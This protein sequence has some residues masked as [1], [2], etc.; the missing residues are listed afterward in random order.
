MPRRLATLATLALLGLAAC[1]A[2]GPGVETMRL[3][4]GAWRVDSID[5]EAF[6]EGARPTL[7]FRTDGRLVGRA[8][9]NSYVAPVELG[10]KTLKIGPIVSTRKACQPDVMD[11]EATFFAALQDVRDFVVSPEGL[12]TLRGPAG[13]IVAER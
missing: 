4:Q 8:P 9:C 2:A 5:D 3:Q 12:L 1:V 7:E 11:Q 13:T 10:G 6:V